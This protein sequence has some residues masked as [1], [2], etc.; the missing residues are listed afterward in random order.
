MKRGWPRRLILQALIHL[1]AGFYHCERT[2]P[3]GASSQLRKGIHKLA[4]YLHPAKA[5]TRRR[6]IG[7]HSQHLSEW[8]LARL[9]PSIHSAHTPSTAGS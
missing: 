1:A 6:S 3:A 7:K 5:S 9:P 4:L 8:G 2:N